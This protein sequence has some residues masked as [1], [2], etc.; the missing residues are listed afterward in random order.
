MMM[1]LC[2]T[3]SLIH[4][5]NAMHP[6][7][8]Q[9]PIPQLPLPS[10]QPNPGITPIQ[11]A[12]ENKK[13]IIPLENAVVPYI[14]QEP[15]DTPDF[16]LLDLISEVNNEVSDEDLILAA[17]QSEGSVHPAP[18]STSNVTCTSN[19]TVM[20]KSIPSTTFTNLKVAEF[21]KLA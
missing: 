19:T 20:K 15:S 10:P 2:L 21:P 12:I 1:G 11:P 8:Q 4:P 17:T 7:I 6:E 16:D 13:E 14:Q 18:I 3:Y 9:S 5:Q